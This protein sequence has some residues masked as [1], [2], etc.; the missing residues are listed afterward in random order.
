MWMITLTALSPASS[1]RC[2][3]GAE[4]LFESNGA[5][6]IERREI[7]VGR[8][9]RETHPAG[10]GARIADRVQQANDGTKRWVGLCRLHVCD[11]RISIEHISKDESNRPLL[12]RS[13]K[14][15]CISYRR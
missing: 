11:M 9:H 4:D 8:A 2:Y 7:G 1:E 12:E 15:A 14:S 13:D 5:S 10:E 3:P 6:S